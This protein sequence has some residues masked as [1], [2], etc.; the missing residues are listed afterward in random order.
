MK[1]GNNFIGLGKN[2][3]IVKDYSN[4]YLIKPD[5]FLNSFH[6]F[7]KETEIEKIINITS[8]LNFEENRNFIFK[9]SLEDEFIQISDVVVGLLGRFL[10]I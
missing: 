2:E 9:D 4:Y 3:Y 10:H 7:D 8:D 1:N 6:I 5:I